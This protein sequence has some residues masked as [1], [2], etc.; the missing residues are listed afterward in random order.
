MTGEENWLSSGPQNARLLSIER[1]TE[2]R[3]P[4]SN[5]NVPRAC[6][7]KLASRFDH[8]LQE[9]PD[10]LY[11]TDQTCGLTHENVSV[12]RIARAKGIPV[13]LILDLVR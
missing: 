11:L 13:T 12:F 6:G 4:W 3:D 5:R 8:V 2:R 9:A 1:L 7:H 10:R